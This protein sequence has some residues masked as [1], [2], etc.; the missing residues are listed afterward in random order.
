MFALHRQ[1]RAHRLLSSGNQPV[2]VLLVRRQQLL[3]QHLYIGRY[4]NKN[5]NAYRESLPARLG[6]FWC[7]S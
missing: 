7:L 2:L 4:W 1:A 6:L 3:V 5:R